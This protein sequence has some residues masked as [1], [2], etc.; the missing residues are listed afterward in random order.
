MS[1]I[2]GHVIELIDEYRFALVVDA[3]T[4]SEREVVDAEERVRVG[5]Y[6]HVW[7]D[8]READGTLFGSAVRL[9]EHFADPGDAPHAE[10]AFEAQ[11]T[12]VWA[13]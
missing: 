10:D 6:V 13:R 4:R 9:P 2:W 11:A 12:G 8:G 7:I 1:V 3:G 5:D